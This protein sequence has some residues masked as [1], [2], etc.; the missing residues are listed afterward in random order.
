[1][2]PTLDN[3]ATP[4]VEGLL[5]KEEK[6]VTDCEGGESDLSL[7]LNSP[8]KIVSSKTNFSCQINSSSHDSTMSDSPEGSAKNSPKSEKFTALSIG[9]KH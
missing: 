8:R 6:E 9:K 2:E 4:V 7:F 1:M 3:D 5:S